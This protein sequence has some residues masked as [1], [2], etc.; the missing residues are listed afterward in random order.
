MK[1][2][3]LTF[4]FDQAALAAGIPLNSLNTLFARKQIWFGKHELVPASRRGI[5]KRLT[6]QGAFKVAILA[7]LLKIGLPPTRA[8]SITMAFTESGSV[9]VSGGAHSDRLPGHLFKHH[10]TFLSAAD[11]EVGQVTQG[12]PLSLLASGTVTICINL[13]KIYAG[14]EV[15]LR[16][17]SS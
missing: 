13:N 4:A 1:A 14:L 7:R 8:W 5:A 17:E 15:A 12:P 16:Q 10:D 6:F 9:S 3:R 11:D 2:R